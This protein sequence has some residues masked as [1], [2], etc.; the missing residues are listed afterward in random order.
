MNMKINFDY[1]NEMD[2]LYLSKGKPKAGYTV[3]LTSDIFIRKDLDNDQTI[4]ADICDVS[5]HDFDEIVAKLPF[6]IAPTEINDIKQE[7]KNK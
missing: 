1:D 5:T 3:K 4:G 6:L 7:L 2:I